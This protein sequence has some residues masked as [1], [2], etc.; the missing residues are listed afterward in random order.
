MS[1]GGFLAEIRRR[2]A[3][4]YWTGW[5]H[6]ALLAAMMLVAPFDHR[7][8]MGLN[9]WMKPMKFAASIAIYAWTVAWLLGLVPGPRW[10][11]WLVS[12]GIGVSMVAEIL[13]IAL[14]A[15]RGTTSHYNIST[16]FDR[17]VF[18]T[19]GGMILLNTLLVALL[20]VLFSRPRPALAPSYR[21]GIRLG[22]A[23]FLAGS[24]VGAAMIL[25]QAH[26][27]GAPDGGLGLPLVNWST[28]AGDLRVSHL[29]GLHALQVFPLVGWILSRKVPSP[30]AATA[31]TV[32]FAF[33]YT[34]LFVLTFAQARA[35]H[36]VM[37]L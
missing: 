2:D 14:Q 24:L 15:G 11:R 37:A 33:V 18:N 20:L 28:R 13:C 19:M 7:T 1:V 26:T 35:G 9:P 12:R 3:L 29:L 23:V 22:L 31:A 25:H 5:F 17:V 34:V 8:V 27:V 21:W 30:R 16:P 36:P 4:L 10:A 6:V 32:M